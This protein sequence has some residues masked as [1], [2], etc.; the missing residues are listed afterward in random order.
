M[1]DEPR[2]GDLVTAHGAVCLVTDVH[3]DRVE[4]RTERGTSVNVD[5]TDV[6]HAEPTP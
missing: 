3:G 2:E 5:R 6:R 4:V 1:A